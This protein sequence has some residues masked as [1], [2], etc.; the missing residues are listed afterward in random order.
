[1]SDEKTKIIEEEVKTEDTEEKKT[2]VDINVALV[3]AE[4]DTV[5]RKLSEAC[6]TIEVLK[7]KLADAESLVYEDTKAG[8]IN[9][10]APKT[11]MSRESLAVMS[12]EELLN[13]QKVLDVAQIP[14]FK[15]GTPISYEKQTSPREKLDSVFDEAQKR[16]KAGNK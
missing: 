3:I 13:M 1:M 15:S 16:R 4:R 10:I 7:K 14:A 12:V 2:I 6:D 8:I 9:D 5:I 11:S